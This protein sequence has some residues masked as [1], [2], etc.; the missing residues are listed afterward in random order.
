MGAFGYYGEEESE[1]TEETSSTNHYEAEEVP[2]PPSWA[3][4]KLGDFSGCCSAEGDSTSFYA[5]LRAIFG[6]SDAPTRLEIITYML[7]WGYVGL[8]LSWKAYRGTL[9]GK[10]APGA[11]GA[12]EADALPAAKQ[13]QDEEAQPDG[14][15]AASDALELGPLKAAGK[16]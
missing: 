8:A 11:P 1:S 14:D 16:A 10:F 7:Y 15:A 9:W 6:Y 3:N 5:L 4:V 13:P 2:I 12:A